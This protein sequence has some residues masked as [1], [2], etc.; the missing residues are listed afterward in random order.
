MKKLTWVF[1]LSAVVCLFVAAPAK[2]DSL[3]YTNGPINGTIVAWSIS[4]GYVLSDSFTIGSN[5]TLTVAQ[6]GL[7]MVPGD[8]PT[9]VKWAIGTT[10]GSSNIASGTSSFF[11]QTNEGL[12]TYGYDLWESSLH[13]GGTPAA[14]TY[15]FS[16]QDATTPNGDAV[17]WDQNN[18]PSAAWQNSIGSLQNNYECSGPCTGSESFQIYGTTTATPE[19]GTA[20]LMLIGLGPLGLM[21]VVRKRTFRGLLQAT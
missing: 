9:S 3:L 10:Q 18:G 11:N 19:P 13:I 4:Y 12:N 2:A 5:S 14:G 21:L 17:D 7:Q 8:T 1:L 20:G 16:L 6:V 15:W